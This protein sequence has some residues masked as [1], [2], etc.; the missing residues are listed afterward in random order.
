MFTLRFAAPLIALVNEDGWMADTEN[1]VMPCDTRV[2]RIDSCREMSWV[3]GSWKVDLTPSSRAAF[4][5]PVLAAPQYA[6]TTFTT[7]AL[8]TLDM[9]LPARAAFSLSRSSPSLMSL[10]AIEPCSGDAL[11]E[12]DGGA[13][14]SPPFPDLLVPQAVLVAAR[15]TARATLAVRSATPL[16]ICFLS[17]V[18]G[19][20]E[21]VGRVRVGREG[22]GERRLPRGSAQLRLDGDDEL[23]IGGGVHR[24]RRSGQ[25]RYRDRRPVSSE[26]VQLHG[27]LP[28][29][30]QRV[31]QPQ[32]EVRPVGVGRGGDVEGVAVAAGHRRGD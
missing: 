17:P 5:A 7:T 21:L 15:V 3:G 10:N 12:P 1:P 8:S 28:R 4:S 24:R 16:F 13:P 14:E 9:S 30:R 19:S 20:A 29:D 26:S 22:E 11:V 6:D 32:C 23:R 18:W 2:F 25:R 31:H 27:V